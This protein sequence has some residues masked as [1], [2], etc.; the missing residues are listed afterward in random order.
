MPPAAPLGPRPRT[1]TP[2]R[3]PRPRTA[4]PDPGPRT[5]T[6]AGAGSLAALNCSSFL[7][8][9]SFSPPGLLEALVSSGGAGGVDAFGG[10]DF[11]EAVVG[12]A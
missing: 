6:P 7:A 8:R 11:G 4:H 10:E 12:D 9:A 1:P 2:D 3:A 5:P